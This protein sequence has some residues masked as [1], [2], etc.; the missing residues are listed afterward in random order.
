MESQSGHGSLKI[1]CCKTVSVV[2]IINV[3]ALILWDGF[4]LHDTDRQDGQGSFLMTAGPSHRALPGIM[5]SR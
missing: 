4:A 1:H 3:S 5:L 2:N